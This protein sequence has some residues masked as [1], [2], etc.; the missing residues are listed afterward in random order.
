MVDLNRFL[1]FTDLLR[2][3]PCAHILQQKKR[4]LL[5]GNAGHLK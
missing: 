2:T 4:R 1:E 5:E 3:H